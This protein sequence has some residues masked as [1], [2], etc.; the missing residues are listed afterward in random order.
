MARLLREYGLSGWRRHQPL[1]GKPDF[2][3]RSER[4]ALFVD[5]CFWHG[6][7]RHYRRPSANVEFWV[8]KLRQNVARDRRVSRALRAQGWIVIRVWECRVHSSISINRIRRGLGAGP[9]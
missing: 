5:G 1:P 6:C 3:W 9:R 2:A 7:P 8:E 4:V